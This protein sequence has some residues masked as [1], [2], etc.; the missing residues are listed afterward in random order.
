MQGLWA[1][2]GRRHCLEMQREVSAVLRAAG[3]DHSVEF[4]PEVG[5]QGATARARTQPQPRLLCMGGA[6]GSVGAEACT[7]AGHGG[8][9]WQSG[10]VTGVFWAHIGCA[11][12]PSRTAVHGSYRS[13]GIALPAERIAIEVDGPQHFTGG[14]DGV[15]SSRTGLGWGFGRARG[16]RGG[17]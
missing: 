14:H 11:L 15:V 16:G 6:A 5:R 9:A 13:I 10:S 1:A 7:P 3:I 4:R 17:G 12:R 8:A 2:G